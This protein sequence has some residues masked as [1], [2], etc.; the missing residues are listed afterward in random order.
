[1]VVIVNRTTLSALSLA[2][3]SFV[4]SAQQQQA[5][6]A[7]AVLPPVSETVTVVEQLDPVTEAQSERSTAVLQGGQQR[8][9]VPGAAELL[10]DDA[11]L[12]IQQRGGGG[13]QQDV[14]I[15]GSSYEQTLVLLNGLRINDAETS[16]FNLDLPVPLD[17]IG[18]MYVLHGAGS[19]LYGSDAVS[20]VV[21]VT[22]ARPDAGSTLRLRAGGG[23]FGG[24]SQAALASWA[25][26]RV[27][28]VLAGAR[29]FSTGFIAD[30]D[31]RSEE[32]SSETRL[33]S[34]AGESDV[35]LA[36]SDRAFGA[37]QFY[38]NYPSW[39]RT[40]GWF[41]ALT[42]QFGEKTQAAL[43]FRRHSDVFVLFRNQPS[44]YENNHID[45]SW[46]GVLR[47]SDTVKRLHA[48][49]DYG[50]EEDADQ[51]NSTNL[52]KHGRNRGAGYLDARFTPGR[53]I[54][55]TVGL[56]EEV[57]G[58]GPRVLVPSFSASDSLRPS[59]KVR[60]AVS[61][62][63]RVP[64]YTDLDYND[65]ANHGN[66]NLKPE[67]A[68]SYEGG[69]DWYPSGRWAVSATGFTSRQT[70]V[71][72]YVR[73]NSNDAYQAENLTHVTLSGAEAALEWRPMASQ[74]VRVSFTA[75]HG[76]QGALNN[77][78][79]KY[80]FNLPLENAVA[81]WDGAWRRGLGT[82]ERLRV[83]HRY[84]GQL[85]AVVDAGVHFDRGP[86]HPYVQITNL[87]NAGYQEIAGVPMQGRAF[88]G[89]L[90]V[91][92]KKRR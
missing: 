21:N 82:R 76:A 71:I 24:N 10:R 28:E 38:G 51:I 37:D 52:G 70:N 19:T 67:F 68:W 74:H 32:L 85:Y 18:G 54:T 48:V 35:L 66:K 72:D 53:N 58:G 30:R 84:D 23:S 49:M 6:L 27:S 91:E 42:Q 13:V 7:P 73:T 90:E 15:R 1:M 77:E 3:A 17:A 9:A 69:V 46:Q 31:Y 89:G 11:S 86:L 2:A 64:T 25:G 75:L 39:E 56:R 83:V 92:L 61:R 65:P 29:D 43:A 62:G 20:G 40:K 79:S 59:W 16:H 5:P 47:R 88:T 41:A 26:S 87:G 8:L 44:I 36:T 12:D 45:T 80:V 33:Q 55:A 4:A 34:A 78:Q 57:I 14:S 60:G 22:T 81:E 63:F 50:L